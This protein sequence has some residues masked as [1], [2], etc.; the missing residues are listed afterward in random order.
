ML[1]SIVR[2]NSRGKSR[3]DHKGEEFDEMVE[4]SHFGLMGW[5]VI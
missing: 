3:I 1:S 4:F 5:P 2:R